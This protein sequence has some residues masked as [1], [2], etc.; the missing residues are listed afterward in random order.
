MNLTLYFPYEER[1]AYCLHMSVC[2]SFQKNCATHNC[3]TL[4]PFDF[5]LGTLIHINMDMIPVGQGQGHFSA[6]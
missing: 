4:N 5:K 6:P 3:R 1:G 2:R